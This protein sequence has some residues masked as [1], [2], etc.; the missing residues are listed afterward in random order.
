MKNEHEMYVKNETVKRMQSIV[1][2]ILCEI[3]SYCRQNGIRYFLS[4]GTCLGAVRH[5]GFIPW[6]DDGDIMMPRDDY[7]KFIKGF[8][9][10][11][12]S[13]FRISTPYNDKKWHLSYTRVWDPNT[14]IIHKTIYNPDIGVNVDI[15]PIDGVYTGPIRRKAYYWELKVLDAICTEA[16]RKQYSDRHRF[17]RLRKI[18]G[19]I[20]KLFGPHIFASMMNALAKR[21]EYNISEYVACSLPVHYGE[22]ETIE[23]KYMSDAVYMDFENSKFP[24]PSGY[25]KYLSNLYG[26][27]Y[28]KV[29]S[30]P[31][32]GTHL[33]EWEVVFD[34]HN[35]KK[36]E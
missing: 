23:R 9:T 30:A 4:G 35:I 29:P 16:V 25:D 19:R 26:A 10:A 22:R 13:R 12:T 3:D 8:E 34:I 32:A 7:E 15:F 31:G 17:V 36:D 14:R 18:T 6:D 28:M 5:H 33:N 27:D 2:E 1:Y 11:N 21:N 20:A 24:V